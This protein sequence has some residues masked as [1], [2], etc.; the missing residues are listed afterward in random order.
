[1]KS[2][3]IHT[4]SLCLT[5]V[6]SSW[7]LN[8]LLPKRGFKQHLFSV[9]WLCV[10]SGGLE[11][12]PQ[13]NGLDSLFKKWERSDRI[14]RA[15]D[16]SYPGRTAETQQKRWLLDV[17]TR[18]VWM[19]YFHSWWALDVRSMTLHPTLSLNAVE[20]WNYLVDVWYPGLMSATTENCPV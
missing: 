16:W 5:V 6:S 9:T 2:S 3:F 8:M 13:F 7:G 10:L 12:R 14:E 1:M 11:T 20:L 18:Q 19:D 15:S 4:T 17:H